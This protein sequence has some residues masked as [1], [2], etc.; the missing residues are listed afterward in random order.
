[1]DAEFNPA[2]YGY[3][4]RKVSMYGE[5]GWLVVDDTLPPLVIESGTG[6]YCILPNVYDLEW[7]PVARAMFG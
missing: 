7:M 1:M 3:L 4:P 2:N 6:W 5:N